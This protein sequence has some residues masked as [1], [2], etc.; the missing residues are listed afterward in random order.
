MSCE[1]GCGFEGEDDVTQFLIEEATAL[2]YDAVLNAEIEADGKT[3]SKP[4][5]ITDPELAAAMDAAKDAHV[6]NFGTNVG[7]SRGGRI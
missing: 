5:E 2:Y 1:C 7:M 4:G 6:K 3:P